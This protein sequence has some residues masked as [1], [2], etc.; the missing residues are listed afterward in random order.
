[1]LPWE[2]VPKRWVRRDEISELVERIRALEPGDQVRLMQRVLT[3]DLAFRL[4]LE[5]TRA[6]A[7]KA[8]KVPPKEL[9]R[10][11]D[12]A[13]REVRKDTVKKLRA[14]RRVRKRS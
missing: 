10:V 7:T 2:P 13:A 8:R 9:D 1:M 3:P 14:A 4:M 12:E 5:E 6:K 11:L